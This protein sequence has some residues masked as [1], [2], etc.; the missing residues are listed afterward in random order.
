MREASK[1]RSVLIQAAALLLLVCG[2]IYWGVRAASKPL[3]RDDLKIEIGDLRSE[4]SEG[5]KFAEQASPDKTTRTFFQEQTSMLADKV[6]D[7]KKK[8]D[9]ATTETGLEVQHWEARHLAGQVQ[10]ELERLTSTFAQPQQ[11]NS[12]KVELEKL[13]AQLKELEESLKQ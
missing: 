6:K 3:G 1:T 10:N 4:A 2:V 7:A 9:D 13:H 8:L 12:V 11:A 5:V